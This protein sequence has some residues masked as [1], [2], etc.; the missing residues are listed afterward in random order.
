MSKLEENQHKEATE[1]I[2]AFQQKAIETAEFTVKNGEKWDYEQESL[3]FSENAGALMTDI[4]RVSYNH[5]NIY[6][7]FEQI[8][9]AAIKRKIDVKNDADE[10]MALIKNFELLSTLINA[11]VSYKSE[12]LL[13]SVQY[14][15]LS[16]QIRRYIKFADEND[17]VCSDTNT[18]KH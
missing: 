10:I 15:D 6:N 4:L 13:L 7:E 14:N 1:F 8:Y 2:T 5:R 11:S 17:T 16:M 3:E 12:A 9:L 18:N